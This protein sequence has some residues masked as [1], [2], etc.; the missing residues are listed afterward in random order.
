M[1]SRTKDLEK[2]KPRTEL[3]KD[4]ENFDNLGPHRIHLGCPCE[5]FLAIKSGTLEDTC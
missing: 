2:L 1:T 3:D 5:R 4:Q